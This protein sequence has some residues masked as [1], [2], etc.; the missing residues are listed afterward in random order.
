M[1]IEKSSQISGG[2]Y[3]VRPRHLRAL[4]S[5]PPQRTIP[6][7]PLCGGTIQEVSSKTG[8]NSSFITIVGLALVV[9]GIIGTAIY[10]TWKVLC[11]AF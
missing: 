4:P 10:L 3:S 9:W 7:V 11:I 1:D 5:P 2:R 6:D 8:F